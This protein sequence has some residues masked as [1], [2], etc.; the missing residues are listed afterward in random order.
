MPGNEIWVKMNSILIPSQD[1]DALHLR[2][3]E[4]GE[5]GSGLAKP[6]FLFERGPYRLKEEP[7]HHRLGL[8][9]TVRLFREPGDPVHVFEQDLSDRLYMFFLDKL[10]CVT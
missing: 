4:G 2:M 6:I 8:A 7:E 10:R 5:L 1:I 3:V 9:M